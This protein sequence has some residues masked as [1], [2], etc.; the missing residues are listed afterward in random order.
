MTKKRTG[1]PWLPA[2]QY[3]RSL[4]AFTVNLLVRDVPVAV[5]FY[6]GVLQAE[7]RYSDPDFAALRMGGLDFM[8]HADHTYEK[9]PWQGVL[10]S[11]ERRGLGVELRLFGIDPDGLAARAAAARATVLAPPVDKPHGWREVWVQDADGYVWAVGV[12]SG[13]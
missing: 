13:G 3:G 10:T 7:V 8:L 9:H 5:A 4:P 11:G 1:D 12:P 6:R 2:G